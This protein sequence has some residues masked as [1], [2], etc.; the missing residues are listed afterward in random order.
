MVVSSTLTG[1]SK[2]RRGGM[3][4]KII[5]DRCGVRI[6][7]DDR[8]HLLATHE[9][10]DNHNKIYLNQNIYL[11]K[12]HMKELADNLNRFIKAYMKQKN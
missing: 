11:C 10:D 4:I 5:C 1:D 12:E 8:M 7:A 9:R 6:T 3:G 2:E